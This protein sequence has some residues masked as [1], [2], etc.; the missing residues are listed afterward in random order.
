MDSFGILILLY[1][2]NIII[3]MDSILLKNP[4]EHEILVKAGKVLDE[5]NSDGSKAVPELYQAKSSGH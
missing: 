2:H 1:V 4:T 3:M 5:R